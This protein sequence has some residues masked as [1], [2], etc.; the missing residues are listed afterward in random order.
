MPDSSFD[1]VL[2]MGPLYHLVNASERRQALREAHRVL[3]PGGTLLAEIIC[4]HAWVL[5]ATLRDRLSQP[6]VWAVFTRN[7]ETGL[8]QDPVTLDAGGFWAYFTSLMSFDPS[9]QALDL[10][11]VNLLPSKAL[12]GYLAIWNDDSKIQV[13]SFVQSG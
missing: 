12:D 11:I 13:H 4:R 10:P 6:D 5:D 9:S 8:S 1:V 7:I 3:R 2:L